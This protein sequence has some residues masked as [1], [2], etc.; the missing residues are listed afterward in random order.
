MIS[1]Q[2]LTQLKQLFKED[3]IE[4]SDGAA[5]EVG[6]WLIERFKSIRLSIPLEKEASFQKNIDEMMIFRSIYK[7]K[8]VRNH[9]MEK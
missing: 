4:L 2:R 3:G 1:S 5:L 6:I 9:A 7:T 8:E